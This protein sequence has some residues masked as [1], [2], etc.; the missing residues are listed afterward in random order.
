MNNYYPPQIEGKL[1]AQYGT[2]LR[3]PFE[4]GYAPSQTEQL[5]AR[6]KQIVSNNIVGDILI[7]TNNLQNETIALF[8][9]P[10]ALLEVGQ[11]YK[12]Q[13]SWD[14]NIYSTVGIFR[15]T[16]EPKVE[17]E[18]LDS[19][20]V[21]YHQNE[22]IATYSSSDPGE[23][24]YQYRFVLARGSEVLESSGLITCEQDSDSVISYRFKTK[25]IENE[26]YAI[27]CI[28]YT[29][30]GL[31][32]RSPKYLMQKYNEYKPYVKAKITAVAHPENGSIAVSIEPPT[33]YSLH[34]K[35]RIFRTSELTN[36]NVWDELA[37]IAINITALWEIFEDKTIQ[38]GVQYKYAIQQYDDK[39]NVYTTKIE[40]EPVACDFE[41][42]FL[43]DGKRQL[44]IKYNPKISSF[45]NVNQEQ[46]I[47]TIGSTYPF[48]FRNGYTNYKEF[49]ISGLISLLMDDNGD[50]NNTIKNRDD[51]FSVLTDLTGINI[52]NEREFK[53]DVL[54][55]L[56]D[57]RPK[58]FR[59][60]S[61]GNYIVRL[62]NTSLSP[63]DTL[64][65]MLHTFSTTAYEIAPYTYNS[66]LE[67][68]L[69]EKISNNLGVLNYRVYN[70]IDYREST[71]LNF[72]YGR[73]LTIH[74]A[75]PGAAFTILTSTKE[76]ID[77]QIGIT[78]YYQYIADGEI[79]MTGLIINPKYAGI[80]EI[81]QYGQV[82][83]PIL[84][85]INGHQVKIHDYTFKEYFSQYYSQTN[86]NT[87]LYNTAQTSSPLG[88]G[89]EKIQHIVKINLLHIENRTI[90]DS[91]SEPDSRA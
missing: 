58:L 47:D 11:H 39:T 70:L 72:N 33:S 53:L 62:M 26:L 15:Y 31:E 17:L 76:Q 54:K 65:R 42:A 63:N 4:A 48:I 44:K 56:T 5:K 84:D 38:Q 67:Y 28:I 86:E 30:G 51:E 49:P 59:S 80:V 23:R 60:P 27:Q 25:I 9:I 45:K 73:I 74:D 90:I 20:Q 64:G 57:G 19:T 61:E 68:G 7:S 75:T 82:E 78:G 88:N 14:S 66:L 10:E 6:I 22:Y 3:I 79:Y 18:G 8:T 24:P 37:D 40:T 1:P 41:D 35:Y 69:I 87:V 13:L 81:G 21:I 32:V 83:Y 77:I 2:I 85:N 36:F 91:D 55:W 16:A 50:F 89:H 46:K 52:A 43:F 29:T 12:I 71:T 34:G